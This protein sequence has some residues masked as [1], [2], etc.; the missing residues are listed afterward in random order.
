MTAAQSPL[1]GHRHG[2]TCQQIRMAFDVSA[3]QIIYE[4]WPAANK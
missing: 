3:M 2:K 1:L 4:D